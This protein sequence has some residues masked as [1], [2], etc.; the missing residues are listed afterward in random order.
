MELSELLSERDKIAE[1][2]ERIIDSAAASFGVDVSS[3]EITD[4]HVPNDL[5]Q[6]LSVLAQSRRA[7]Q[8]KIAEAEAEKTVALKLQEAGELM[9][10]RAM[11][12]YR[13]NVLE[14][15]G[16]EEGS[17][18]V[19]YGLG[20]TDIDMEKNIAATAATARLGQNQ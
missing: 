3:V 16:R 20:G 19:I 1:S 9:D 5:I 6:E 4:I 7:A 14:R 15:I 11:E 17:Q 13:L 10:T 12:M 2:L 18:I 8:A